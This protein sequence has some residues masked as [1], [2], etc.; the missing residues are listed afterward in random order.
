MAPPR[1]VQCAR[2]TTKMAALE[3]CF[4]RL[5]MAGLRKMYTIPSTLGQ[6]VL[7]FHLG[8]LDKVL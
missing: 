4:Q 7:C 8:D 5:L 3:F 2:C 1:I 6:L